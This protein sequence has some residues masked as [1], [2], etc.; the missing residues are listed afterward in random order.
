MESIYAEKRH[1]HAAFSEQGQ[2]LLYLK[3]PMLLKVRDTVQPTESILINVDQREELL[4]AP[5]LSM[6]DKPL[7]KPGDNNMT[8]GQQYEE[9]PKHHVSQA[10]K[11]PLRHGAAIR[12]AGIKRTFDTFVAVDDLHMAIQPGEIYGFLGSNGAGKT[13]TIKMLVGLL[14]PDQ[15]HVEIVGHDIKREPVAAKAALGY[16]ADRS[17]LYERLTGREFLAFLGQ[18]R[19]LPQAETEQRIAYLL[20]LLDLVG[21]AERLCGAYSFGMKRKLS[22]AGALLHSPQ[23]LILDEP[24]NGLDPR[25][26]RRVKDLLLAL[27]AG[28][29]A[30][31]LSTH[32]LATA[33]TLCHRVGILHKGRLLA[34]G[35]ATA[36][37]QMAAAPNLES[38]FLDLTEEQ[39]EKVVNV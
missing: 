35:S 39:A 23:V 16:V 27:A 7:S 19:G 30:I 38:V 25:S 11:Q 4:A 14:R 26:N 37:R 2:L 33:E 36:L 1:I 20:D 8:V 6:M 29:T 28:G 17:L 15:G 22:L 32:D 5:G 21:H 24:L 31:L 10:L 34:E 9:G 13:T 12:I 18:M 3:Q